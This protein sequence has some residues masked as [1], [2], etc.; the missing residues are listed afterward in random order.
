M[1]KVLIV[2]DDPMVGLI[3]KK[4]LEQMGIMTSYGPVMIEEEVFKYVESEKIDLILLDEY[5]PQK[6]GMDILKALRD[7]GFYCDV[8]MITAANNQNEVEKAYAYGVI[9]YLIKPFEFE[10]FQEAIEKHLKRR[11]WLNNKG[12]IKQVDIDRIEERD[13]TNIELPK[14]K[15]KRIL[16]KI[17]AFLQQ[18]PEKVWT[19]RELAKAIQISNVTIKKYMDYLEETQQ[20]DV[21]LTSGNVGRPEH[22]YKLKSNQYKI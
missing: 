7:K 12:T 20:I 15:N 16:D 19:L 17:I 22:Q 6:K 14:G 8:I 4:Y 5:L 2:E 9:D 21:K 10:R 13:E 1:S 3:N 18:E 11:Q